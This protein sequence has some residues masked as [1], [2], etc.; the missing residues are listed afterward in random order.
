MDEANLQHQQLDTQLRN[1]IYAMPGHRMGAAA[2]RAE[3]RAARA[4]GVWEQRFDHGGIDPLTGRR[5][6]AVGVD[7]NKRASGGAGSGNFGSMSMAM[8]GDLWKRTFGKGG[9]VPHST[10]L[11][12]GH[13][14]GASLPGIDDGSDFNAFF[15]PGDDHA[16]TPAET[17]NQPQDNQPSPKNTTE[18]LQSANGLLQKIEQHAGTLEKVWTK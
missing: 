18:L 2:A 15:H 12:T 14:Q 17:Y 4:R 5:R 7:I 11:Q 6:T 8:S 1:T 13:V 9:R 10:A 3:S 16:A